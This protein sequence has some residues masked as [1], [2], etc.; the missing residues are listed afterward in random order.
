MDGC[1]E[2]LYLYTKQ[3]VACLHTHNHSRQRAG[4]PLKV[5]VYLNGC[6]TLAT[7]RLIVE[8]ASYDE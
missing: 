8:H 3:R 5:A 6:I 2:T 4:Q 7:L 1:C